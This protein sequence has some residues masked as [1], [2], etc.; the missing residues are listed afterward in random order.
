MPISVGPTWTLFTLT[1][2]IGQPSHESL[3]LEI[4]TGSPGEVLY[5]DGIVVR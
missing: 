3:R 1:L 4:Y 5:V 2:P